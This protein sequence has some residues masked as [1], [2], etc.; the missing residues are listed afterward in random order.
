MS[1]K[2]TLITRATGH[3][4]FRKS[5]PP[6][7]GLRTT[8]ARMSMKLRLMLRPRSLEALNEP[9]SW[10][11]DTNISFDLVI[12][13]PLFVVGRDDLITTPQDALRG[14][15]GVIL[16]LVLGIKRPLLI[17]R[18][19]SRTSLDCTLGAAFSHDHRQ[20]RDTLVGNQRDRCA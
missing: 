6:E 3:L 13:Y 15:N 8:K 17:S 9:D 12:I 20:Q 2:T 4:G 11:K 14:T 18:L 19:I 7:T 5:T 1:G 10:M 16:R